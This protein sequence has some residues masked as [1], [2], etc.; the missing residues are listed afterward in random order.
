MSQIDHPYFGALDS[1]AL[2]ETDV[3]WEGEAPLDGQP[4]AEV[5]LWVQ[6]GLPFD[7][8]R[9]DFF[10]ALLQALPAHDQ[11]ARGQLVQYL[12]D[13]PEY[14]R[15]HLEELADTPVL[16]KLT[17]NSVRSEVPVQDFVA[18][19]QLKNIGL[20]LENVNEDDAPS[21][22]VVMDYMIDPEHSD[23]IL[24]VKLGL[25]GEVMSIDWES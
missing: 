8:K 21:T 13:A 3:C 11:R 10:A 1:G 5:W 12:Q 4:P 22:S 16:D 18:A 2:T 14:L 25:D 6:P 9:L 7:A 19:M 17:H 23:E 15:F 20:W 24:A